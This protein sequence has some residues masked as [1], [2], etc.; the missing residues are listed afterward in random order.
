MLFA[1]AALIAVAGETWLRLAKPFM[2][3]QSPGK[4]FVPKV[5]LLWEP[6]AEI[7]FTNRLDYWAVSRTNSLGFVDREPPN[8]ERAAAGCRAAVIGDSYVEAKLLSPISRKFH[9][10]LETLAAEALPHLELAASAFARANTGQIQQMPFYDEYARHL[11]PNLLVLVFVSN[12]FADN[13]PILRALLEGRDPQYPP[14]EPG[15][16]RL[17]DGRIEWRPPHPDR[18]EEVLLP[19]PAKPNRRPAWVVRLK[20]AVKLSWFANWLDA[21][22]DVLFR[23]GHDPALIMHA[24]MLRRRPDYAALLADWR[25]TTREGL[26]RTFSESSL[27]PVFEDA[28]DYTAFALE[29]FK[30]RAD[31]GGSA[32]VILATHTAKLH[33]PLV[34]ERMSAMAAALG[35]PVIDQADYILRQGAALSD[36][37]WLHDAHW[38]ADGHRWAAEALLEWLQQNP[39]VCAPDS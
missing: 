22:K 31:R 13:S 7:R 27:P 20:Q 19:R 1:G 6:N 4:E 3:P 39:Q 5:G 16:A 17:P 9:V 30:Q 12:D 33:G 37:Q 29:Q 10:R 24:D 15:A 2:T 32:L 18:A 35:I 26:Y 14:P 8:P 36:A 21:K 25:P 11:R 38:N 23:A 28:L 34:F